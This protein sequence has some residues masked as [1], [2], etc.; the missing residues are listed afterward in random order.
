M[1]DVCDV[2][3]E[4]DGSKDEGNDQAFIPSARSPDGYRTGMVRGHIALSQL[5]SCNRRR[6]GFVGQGGSRILQQH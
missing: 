4:M 3:D 5:L 2:C 6:S 1:S